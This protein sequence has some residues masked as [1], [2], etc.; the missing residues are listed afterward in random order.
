M[1]VGYAEDKELYHVDSHS[2]NIQQTPSK[3]I[4]VGSR[5]LQYQLVGK[6]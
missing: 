5:H 1:V 4:A 2:S 6:C 3:G